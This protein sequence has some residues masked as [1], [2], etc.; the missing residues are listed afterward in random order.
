MFQD[1]DGTYLTFQKDGDGYISKE[2]KDYTLKL[3]NVK[4]GGFEEQSPNEGSE[5]ILAR[6]GESSED[7]RPSHN[8]TVSSGG[9]TQIEKETVQ[10]TILSSCTLTDK[11]Q[12]VYRFDANGSL[13]AQE[14]ANGNYILYEYDDQGRLAAVTTN[15]NQTLTMEY[16][17]SDLLQK[18]S[19]PDG[20]KM[21]Y[22][23]DG[24]GNLKEARR[25]SADQGQTVSYP[26]SYD[27]EGWLV[28]IKDAKGNSY[29]IA[30]EDKKAVKF[31]KPNGEYQKL[32]YG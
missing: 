29:A 2:S 18:I 4:N 3:E 11:D 16:D 20:T 30:Y 31:T 15:K 8:V 25:Q 28:Q 17:A 6:S 1:S 13:T 10:K 32:V 27:Q 26:Y 24:D 19:L 9:E 21:A 14:D 7:Y 22:T 23:Y 5:S 12:N